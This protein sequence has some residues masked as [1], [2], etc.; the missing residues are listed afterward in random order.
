MLLCLSWIGAVLII[1]GL[2]WFFTNTYR[3]RLLVD[4][5]NK[6]LI[7]NGIYEQIDDTSFVSANPF[8]EGQWFALSNSSNHVYAFTLMY[9]GN[10]AAC[11]AFTGEGGGV[12]AILP[13][14]G[15]SNQIIEELPPP[16]Y[17]FY[18]NRIEQTAQKRM[19]GRNR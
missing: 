12:I 9:G 13:L 7:T 8:I 5:V 17:R 4:T 6:T 2:V 14:G 10:T 3:A 18:A 19:G 15:N 1:G 11:A 16:V